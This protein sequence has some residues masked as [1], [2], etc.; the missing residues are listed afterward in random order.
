MGANMQQ[1]IRAFTEAQAY[2]GPSLIIAYSPC[3]SHGMNMQKSIEEE[4][5]AVDCGYWPLYRYN[6]ETKSFTLDSKE[7]N[8][9]FREFLMGENR[10]KALKKAQPNIAD[11]LFEQ[12]EKDCLE[13]FALYK[14]L[15][16]LWD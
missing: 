4:K 6:P 2:N 8:G 16:K 9:Q 5:R 14:K 7:P 3:I 13:R 15:S 1:L 10:F 11:A 12:A